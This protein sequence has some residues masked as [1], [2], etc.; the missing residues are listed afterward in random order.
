MVPIRPRSPRYLCQ[1]AD[2]NVEQTRNKRRQR[3]FSRRN[4]HIIEQTLKDLKRPP[5]QTRRH[6]SKIE[7]LRSARTFRPL[8]PQRCK[9]LR[10]ISSSNL[11]C[12]SR[13]RVAIRVMKKMLP[14]RSTCRSGQCSRPRPRLFHKLVPAQ[15]AEMAVMAERAVVAVVA[16]V[17]AA[18]AAA[19]AER[20]YKCRLLLCRRSCTCP[21]ENL[22]RDPDTM[23]LC[24]TC[25]FIG[26]ATNL[27]KPLFGGRQQHCARVCDG[28]NKH[29]CPM[30]CIT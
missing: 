5:S 30:P 3:K 22:G 1:P 2:D 6:P 18:A 12:T 16:V 15:M 27:R 10:S 14:T 19:V 28:G 9:K 21:P 13:C 24:G 20:R 7:P 4:H 17:A 23:R 11:R 8:V 29:D 26:R 25:E